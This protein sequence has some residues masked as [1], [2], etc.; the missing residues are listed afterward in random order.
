MVGYSYLGALFNPPLDALREVARISCVHFLY[1]SSYAV[2]SSDEDFI[3]FKGEGETILDTIEVAP[4]SLFDDLLDL[5][6]R[7]SSE[8][9]RFFSY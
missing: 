1:L 5:E 9:E 8:T 6:V 2:W 7:V 3:L 4:L